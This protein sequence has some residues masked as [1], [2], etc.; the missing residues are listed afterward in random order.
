MSRETRQAFEDWVAGR[1]YIDGNGNYH[2]R[3]ASRGN[4][5]KGPIAPWNKTIK[6]TFKTITDFHAAA[7]RA[8]GGQV[9]DDD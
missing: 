6:R 1:V 9:T 8:T 3:D 4:P 5:R 7:V 2:L